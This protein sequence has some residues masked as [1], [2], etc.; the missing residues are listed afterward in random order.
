MTPSNLPAL[1]PAEENIVL[2]LKALTDLAQASGSRF[3]GALLEC[4]T[5]VE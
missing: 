2:P 5:W 4:L 3:H 1:S